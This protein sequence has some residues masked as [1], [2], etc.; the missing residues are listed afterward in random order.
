M[1]K[2]SSLFYYSLLSCIPMLGMVG[3]SSHDISGPE[4]DTSAKED[5]RYL[6]VAFSNPSST[7]A[8]TFDPGTDEENAVK[9]VNFRFYDANGN[10]VGEATNISLEFKNTSTEGTTTPSTSR[11]AESVVQLSLA[12]GSKQ[13]AYV[14]AFINPVDW[15]DIESKENMQSLRDAKR[16]SYKMSETSGFA[17]NNSVYY[18]NDPVS[19]ASNVKIMATPILPDQLYQT[20]A[21]A[22]DDNA[23]VVN[24]Y[25]ERYAAK[26]NLTLKENCIDDITKGDFTLTFV[27]EAW[28]VNADAPSM[29]AS[30][31]FENSDATVDMIPTYQEVQTVLGGWTTWNDSENHRSYWGCSPSYYATDFPA[32]SDNIIDQASEGQTGA[33]EIIGNYKLRYYS[34]NQIT[35]MSAGNTSPGKGVTAFN[36]SGKNWK[37][38][39]ENTMGKAAFESLNP[40]AAAPSAIIVGRYDVQYKGTKIND[41]NSFYLYG[42]KLFFK[43]TVPTSVPEGQLIMDV[44][45][46]NNQVLAINQNGTPLDASNATDAIKNCFEVVHP[47]KEVRGQQQVPHRFVTL[48]LKKDLTASQLLGLY[49]KPIGSAYWQ[50]VAPSD[51]QALNEIIVSINRILWAQLGNAQAFTNNKCYYSIPI[52]HLGFTENSNGAPVDEK[53]AIDWKKVR[54]GDFGLVR[55]HVYSIEVSKISGLAS[56]IED[57]DNPLVPS[58]DETDYWI[59]YNV[60]ILNWRIVPAQDVKL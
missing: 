38:V 41:L 3:C 11:I 21:A 19:G 14:I 49:Y 24:I 20:L 26:V 5:V 34:Y 58:M 18:G 33:G 53:G 59:K 12:R 37:Y 9:S 8:A 28:S 31:R 30:K 27:P 51:G 54:V 35:N 10:P 17:M 44:L 56:G 50:P 52:Q 6:K 29:Y 15:E 22:E 48:Q 4:D 43:Q 40:K 13:P 7:R 60:N 32:V 47:A 23:S 25:I 46:N 42:D 16:E 45:L 57:L 39:L 2:A 36:N 55:N 1:K